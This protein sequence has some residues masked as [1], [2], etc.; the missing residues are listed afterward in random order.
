[1][2]FGDLR[3]G[4]FPEDQENKVALYVRTLAH[5]GRNEISQGRVAASWLVVTAKP[6]KVAVKYLL[7]ASIINVR[8]DIV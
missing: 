6:G 2:L 7:S 3:P 5:S 4:L 8:G 1:M